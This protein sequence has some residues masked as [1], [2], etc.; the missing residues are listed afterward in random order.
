MKKFSTYIINLGKIKAEA[1]FVPSKTLPKKIPITTPF[2]FPITDNNNFV[3]AR[4]KMNWWNPLGGHI[5]KGENWKDTM[6]REAQ[7]E[8]GVIISNI[9]IVGY[10]LIK[11]LTKDPNNKYPDIS[12]IPITIS[13]AITV[14]KNWIPMET[15]E[16]KI[17]NIAGV[18][19]VLKKRN[20]NNQM[21]EIFQFVVDNYLSSG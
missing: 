2:T 3:L 18:K 14:I 16:R 15:F 17:F 21:Y 5:E 12:Q 4:D 8:G 11:Q 6:I 13:K 10:V 7:E 1:V 9:K 19:S 20:D